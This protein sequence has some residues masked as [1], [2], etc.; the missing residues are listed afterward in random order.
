MKS[1]LAL[2]IILVS[3]SA[4]A[5]I[6][7]SG[8]FFALSVADLDASAKWYAIAFDMKPTMHSPKQNGNEVVVLQGRG[9]TV[10]LIH[11]DAAVPLASLNPKAADAVAVHGFVKAGILVDDFAGTLGTLSARGVTFA[12]GP[13]PER[14]DQKANVI[15]KDN[16]GNLIQ[17]IAR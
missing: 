13:F 4:P 17:I 14:P 12:Y 9:L 16:A 2:A 3:T 15:I 10:E 1:F 5:P 7:A 11:S 8:A 6:S